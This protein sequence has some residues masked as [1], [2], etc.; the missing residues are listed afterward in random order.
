[1]QGIWSLILLAVLVS[2][3]AIGIK[4][5][6]EKITSEQE[7]ALT[8]RANWNREEGADACYDYV[9]GE[10]KVSGRGRRCSLED[11][12]RDG[13]AFRIILDGGYSIK[14]DPDTTVEELSNFISLIGGGK[15]D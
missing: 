3:T 13:D 8:L 10:A 9:S 1:M 2:V 4:V 7:S 12:V 5:M 6:A 15:N 14:V 11:F